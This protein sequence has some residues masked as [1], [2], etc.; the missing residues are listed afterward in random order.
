MISGKISKKI[1]KAFPTIEKVSFQILIE[2]YNQM[3]QVNKYDLNWEE[4]QFS[5]ELVVFMK[6]RNLRKQYELR[7]DIERKL[8]NENKPPIAENNPKNLPRIDINISSWRFQNNEELEYFFEAKNVSEKNWYKESGAKVD[9]SSSQRRYIKTGIEN[10]R[11]GRYYN[12]ALVGYILQ[13]NVT[14]II[15]NINS[16]LGK[17]TNTIRVIKQINYIKDFSHC[18]ESI[19]H[20]KDK[21]LILK[22]IFLRF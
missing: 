6:K 20:G 10:F 8:F 12:G 22:H 17:E 14:A 3:L 11:T 18:Y 2:A 13:G 7:I 21:E 1:K 19:H 15:D 9:A 5:Q 16:C 4:E